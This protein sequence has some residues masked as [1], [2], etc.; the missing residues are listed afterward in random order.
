MQLWGRGCH[1]ASLLAMGFGSQAPGSGGISAGVDT[2]QD[3]SCPFLA[4]RRL[5]RPGFPAWCAGA[6]R[7]RSPPQ[8]AWRDLQ[9]RGADPTAPGGLPGGSH[10]PAPRSVLGGA[11]LRGSL[12][13]R[14]RH[15]WE[16]W[17]VPLPSRPPSPASGREHAVVLRSQ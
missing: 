17:A 8:H 9:R 12:A 6:A 10:L 14:E 11:C 1:Q 16:G 15:L 13:P 2:R 7:G 4:P 5:G 3:V